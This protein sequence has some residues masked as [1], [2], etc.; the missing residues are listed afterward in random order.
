MKGRREKNQNK[1][2]KYQER[3]KD[4]L[5][6]QK[7]ETENDDTQ[8]GKEQEQRKLV[9]EKRENNNNQDTVNKSQN[10]TAKS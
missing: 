3:A 2:N 8:I 9:S 10:A 1:I 4:F 5:E 7:L 6:K